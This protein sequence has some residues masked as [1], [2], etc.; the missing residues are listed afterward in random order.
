[1]SFFIF[2]KVFVHEFVYVNS[3]L[4]KS[5]PRLVHTIRKRLF[6]IYQTTFTFN[7]QFTSTCYIQECQVNVPVLL[8]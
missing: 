4:H 7:V 8:S 1:V 6:L 2:K 5:K 3:T